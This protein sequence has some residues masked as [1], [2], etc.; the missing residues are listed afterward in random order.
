MEDEIHRRKAAFETLVRE[1]SKKL[2]KSD[3][4]GIEVSEGGSREKGGRKLLEYLQRKGKF[5]LWRTSRL[6]QI[7][8]ECERYDLEVNSWVELQKGVG[9]DFVGT[10]QLAGEVDFLQSEDRSPSFSFPVGCLRTWN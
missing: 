8:K 10:H 9:L 7:L 4:D 6:R 1:I 3:M 2:S 5:S